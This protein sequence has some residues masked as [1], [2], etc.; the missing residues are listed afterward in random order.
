MEEIIYYID[1]NEDDEQTGMIRNSFVKNPAVEV[2]YFAFSETENMVT[3][4][5]NNDSKQSFMS[6]SMLADT[7]IP[8][9]IDKNTG[10]PYSVVFTK[11]AIRRIVNKFVETANIN[12]VS[13]NHSNQI[14]DGVI[15]SEH[16]ILEKGR[17]EI[18]LFK[19]VPD[20]SWI[21]TY[22]VKNKELYNELKDN[23]DF[24]GFS[25]EINAFIEE[26]F[27]KINSQESVI[28][29]IVFND[30]MTDDDKIEKIKSVLNIK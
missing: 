24:T 17:I 8:R 28:K 11:D 10:K 23:P 22:Y 15:L 16:F 1:I 12:E 4:S 2:P 25:I 26:A 27:S 30:T 14:I 3:L 29:D 6:V 13:F 21:T 5:F 9:G 19:N 7:P 20:G 18:P